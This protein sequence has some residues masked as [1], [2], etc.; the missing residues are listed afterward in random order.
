MMLLRLQLL[1]GVG[2]ASKG[3]AGKGLLLE[4]KARHAEGRRGE[5]KGA[6]VCLR[7]RRDGHMGGE[8]H[9][10]SRGLGGHLHG[11]GSVQLSSLWQMDRG[12]SPQAGDEQRDQSSA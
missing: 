9:R 3:V 12:T 8:V 1:M 5:A 2:A 6:R 4:G 7:W 11:G 10:A